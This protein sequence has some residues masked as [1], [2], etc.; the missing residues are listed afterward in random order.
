MWQILQ[1]NTLKHAFEKQVKQKNCSCRYLMPLF[2]V[3]NLTATA[4]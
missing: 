1:I 4:T 3:D 2:F